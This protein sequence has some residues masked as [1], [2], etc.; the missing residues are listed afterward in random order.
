MGMDGGAGCSDWEPDST[1]NSI[2]T[3]TEAPVQ[4]K[5]SSPESLEAGFCRSSSTSRLSCWAVRRTSCRP[6]CSTS[7]SVRF[8][9]LTTPSILEAGSH[10][11]FPRPSSASL[12]RGK[13]RTSC[14]TGVEVERIVDPPKGPYP[15]FSPTVAS[16]SLFQGGEYAGGCW[17][18]GTPERRGNARPDRSFPPSPPGSRL[19][20]LLPGPLDRRPGTPAPYDRRRPDIAIC[21]NACAPPFGRF[22]SPGALCPDLP[23]SRGR[24]IRRGGG[25]TSRS[26][27]ASLCPAVQT[28]DDSNHARQCQGG[29]PADRHLL[30]RFRRLRHAVEILLPVAVQWRHFRLRLLLFTELEIRVGSIAL[31]NPDGRRR[32]LSGWGQRRGSWRSHGSAVE[33]GTTLCP[34]CP[35]RVEAINEGALRASRRWR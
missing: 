17:D 12:H 28:T 24:R 29:D 34:L 35:G 26:S 11:A 21:R 22:L 4:A 25:H 9:A 6:T 7:F 18:G 16:F 1:A 3:S 23:R 33:S 31:P 19:C 27:C 13:R 10:A 30:A 5:K 2:S 14:Y 20:H 32:T 15:A 8:T